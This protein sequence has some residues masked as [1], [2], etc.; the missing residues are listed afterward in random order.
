MFLD[1]ANMTDKELK[2][3][4][5]TYGKRA[6]SRIR[7]L[8]KAYTTP[9]GTFYGR[10]S[11]ILERYGDYNTV[12]KGKSRKALE[13]SLNKA[14]AILNARSST[15]KGMQEIDR[16]RL[17]TFKKN[18]P[19]I[20]R[21]NPEEKIDDALWVRAMKIMGKLQAAEKGTKYDSD[22][23]IFTAWQ[24]AQEETSLDLDD[25]FEEAF[26]R[27]GSSSDYF[28]SADLDDVLDFQSV[29]GFDTPFD[30]NYGG[31]R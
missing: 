9:K 19:N 27:I 29:N 26:D 7:T 14:M 16:E 10:K 30:D 24:L 6:M 2:K 5:H 3:A 31:F 1:I 25:F 13:L 28:A 8:E 15:I 12:V 20:G 4:I 23:Q 18:H 17:E 21:R 22:E 11:Y